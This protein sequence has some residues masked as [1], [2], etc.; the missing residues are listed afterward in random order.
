MENQILYTVKRVRRDTG[1]GS[2]V[3]PGIAQLLENFGC[4]ICGMW[5]VIVDMECSR[6]INREIVGED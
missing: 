3:I 1:N 6:G 2:K 5:D 4:G